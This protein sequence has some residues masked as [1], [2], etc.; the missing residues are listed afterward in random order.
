[1]TKFKIFLSVVV[2]LNWLIIATQAFT[3][4]STTPL[5]DK[6]KTHEELLKEWNPPTNEELQSALTEEQSS[7]TEEEKE[8]QK[9]ESELNEDETN[10]IPIEEVQQKEET[11]KETDQTEEIKEQNNTEDKNPPTATEVEFYHKEISQALINEME[12]IAPL[13]KDVITYDDLRHVVVTHLGFDGESYQGNLIVNKD[14]ADEVVDIFK[15]V[16]ESKYP[17]QQMKLMNEY[18]NNDDESMKANNTSGFNYR[19]IA[20]TD[21]LS[22]HAYGLAIDINPLMNPYVVDDLVSPAE[23]ESYADRSTSKEG[24]ITEGDALHEAFL[25]RG[26]KWGGYWKNSKDYQHFSKTNNE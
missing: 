11:P 8:V 4:D 21:T 24:M 1:M 18:N 22:Y 23:G 13:D 9:N 12:S 5:T 19:D 10:E 7:N 6:N 26:W 20:G 14:V 16:Y 3:K 17:I 2:G 25:K 15:E